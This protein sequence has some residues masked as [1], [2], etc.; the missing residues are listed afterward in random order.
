MSSWAELA[1]A[2]GSDCSE[3]GAGDEVGMADG[4]LEGTVP[5]L[6][7]SVA[8]RDGPPARE[9]ASSGSS[10]AAPRLLM[11]IKELEERNAQR[12]P[13]R[14]RRT[15]L[16]LEAV[17][18]VAPAQAQ[19]SPEERKDAM[20]RKLEHARECKAAKRRAGASGPREVVKA[21]AMQAQPMEEE[22]VEVR[23]DSGFL[24][25]L[26]VPQVPRPFAICPLGTRLL[27]L[28]MCPASD[29]T[30][31]ALIN[32]FCLT[33][34]AVISS[35]TAAACRLAIDRRR[36]SESLTRI[37]CALVLV[38]HASVQSMISAIASCKALEP[39][40]L[41]ENVSY[42]ETPMATR[43]QE[44]AYNAKQSSQLGADGQ[45]VEQSDP[46]GLERIVLG[47]DTGPAKLFQTTGSISLLVKCPPDE[48]GNREL[49]LITNY[50]VPWVQ[51]LQSSSAECLKRA[52]LETSS[53]PVGSRAF[54][55][56]VRAATSDR[57]AANMKAER[58][59]LVDR[60]EGWLGLHAA[61]DVHRAAG[62]QTKAFHLAD[63]DISNMIRLS[64]SLRLSGNM[65]R[66]RACMVN[67][68]R[69]RLKIIQHPPSPEA[70]EYR[71]FCFDLFLS[72][73]PRAAQ[74]RMDLWWW[75]NGDWRDHS[76]IQHYPRRSGGER[77]SRDAIA[78]RLTHILVSALAGK[79]PSTFP[80]HRWT[81]VDLSLD[82]LGLMQCVHGV[83]AHAYRAFL[84]A[85]GHQ[86]ARDWDAELHR[87]AIMDKQALGGEF[88]GAADAND[89]DGFDSGTDEMQP[90]PQAQ[91]EQTLPGESWGEVDWAKLNSK[92]RQGGYAF[93]RSA[94]LGKLM[95]LRVCAEPFR[96]LMSEHFRL[97]GE[98]WEAKQRSVEAKATGE[99]ATNQREFRVV[100]A[101]LHIVEDAFIRDVRKLLL[102]RD[103]W[104][105]LPADS[106]SVHFRA[107]TF[108]ILSRMGCS[109]QELL[110]KPHDSFPYRLFLLLEDPEVADVLQGAKPCEL[111]SFSA[112]FLDRYR[113]KGLGSTEALAT[114][115]VVARNLKL[116]IADLEAR[117]A[118]LRRFLKS[119]PMAKIPSL[120]L[121]SASWACLRFAKRQVR[122]RG[123]P[124]INTEKKRV[125]KG[126]V[127]ATPKH[128][129]HGRSAF[130]A[131]VAT[132]SAGKKA[133]FKELHEQYASM[134]VGERKPFLEMA[135]ASRKAQHPAGG[136]RSRPFGI[137]LHQA[138][139]RAKQRRNVTIW[140]KH[141]SI[142]GDAEK[143]QM[144]CSEVIAAGGAA[145]HA[146]QQA[147]R[148]FRL[149]Q[150]QVRATSQE[151][152]EVLAR[153]R[154]RKT[155]PAFSNS[156]TDA[157]PPLGNLQAHFVQCP[158]MSGRAF[159][160]SPESA[161]LAEK[162][163]S[164]A[165]Q[166]PKSQVGLALDLDWQRK[167]SMV[168]D[169]GLPPIPDRSHAEKRA[170]E[171]FVAGVCLCSSEGKKLKQFCNAFLNKGLKVAC[172]PHT[173]ERRM[174]HE[175]YVVAALQSMPLPLAGVDA[176]HIVPTHCLED[177]GGAPLWLHIGLMYLS[178]F[179]PT[180]HLMQV[181]EE[182]TDDHDMVNL[183]PTG[184]FSSFYQTL[185]DLP[186]DRCWWVH[187]L[188]IVDSA[189]PLTSVA[190]DQVNVEH[191]RGP[192]LFWPPRR[193]RGARVGSGGGPADAIEDVGHGIG[194]W[195]DGEVDHEDGIVEE[196]D[197]AG[198]DSPFESAAMGSEEE[199]YAAAL[200]AF[201]EE[202]LEAIVEARDQATQPPE[203]QTP[204][205]DKATMPEVVGQVEQPAGRVEDALG[206]LAE[207]DAV[208][209]VAH[210]RQAEALVFA[211]PGPPLVPPAP[212]APATRGQVGVGQ[213][214]TYVPGGFITFY[215]ATAKSKARFQAQCLNPDHGPKCR[216]TRAAEAYQTQGVRVAQGRPLGLLAAWL[217]ASTTDLC[218]DKPSHEAIVS[219]LSRETRLAARQTL[220][221]ATNGLELANRERPRRPGE[222]EEPSDAP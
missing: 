191:F 25:T 73:G 110:Y 7:P 147:V 33:T 31:K 66:F 165:C 177:P 181:G 9:S 150:K 5:A 18:E 86:Q 100:V 121:L 192:L 47:E 193:Q 34:R 127:K 63:D 90:E 131:F 216:L 190:P 98:A 209:E 205:D 149:D 11:N 167:A 144:I 23:I 52:L 44:E 152:D 105:F 60:G 76:C 50:P 26:R 154:E 166:N 37:A 78:K 103:S 83:L 175:G 207:P 200:G 156:I 96:R 170:M 67:L 43:T 91:A 46:S 88:K 80:R 174:L 173:A 14:G 151:V 15:A 21:L 56:K 27:P 112:G 145:Q 12:R 19:P 1:F 179:R 17:V 48:D 38:D 45:L 71:Q 198:G 79:A 69:A 142:L 85:C 128:R 106:Q 68:V 65:R 64:L 189:R 208:A 49:L 124:Q 109:V 178:P 118:S 61:C 55:L 94:P 201:F 139:E 163:V 2:S 36:M 104:R 16:L 176:G 137:S 81:G 220:L 29:D 199:D 13:Q 111:D 185:Q 113:D 102:E 77:L 58:S 107:L 134:S 188:K 135:E 168:D 159:E 74:R 210:P 97:S 202:E 182:Q 169:E 187:F 212:E 217:E 89:P 180:F 164:Y 171:C 130:Q 140:R 183:V 93:V 148:E 22:Q 138:V 157:Q 146:T 8:S 82:E 153:F 59:L 32:E 70:D 218:P 4:P 20:M 35:A 204:T 92:F 51:N 215:L 72:R 125:L 42:D 116:D 10:G 84:I 161:S 160:F 6:V 75:L 213:H 95:M 136:Q 57:L 126:K 99:G 197:E 117:H 172:G 114:L 155:Q 41:L 206:V 24:D 219:F 211:E 122:C 141:K 214:T 3:D 39:V 143:L 158:W 54:P 162:V 123:R 194:E 115:E 132:V 129:R 221:A 203:V 133:N 62:S 184:T 87:T 196:E 101:A 186:L 195:G 119:A 53:V 120:K 28:T 40:L 108:R 30:V 222:A